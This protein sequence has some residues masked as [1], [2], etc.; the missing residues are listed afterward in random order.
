MDKNKLTELF[1]EYMKEI[2]KRIGEKKVE[3]QMKGTVE[4]YIRKPKKRE[5]K[6]ICF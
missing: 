2:Y 3:T 6:S 1:G 5:K 4:K